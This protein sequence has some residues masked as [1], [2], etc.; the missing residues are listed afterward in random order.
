MRFITSIILLI[1]ICN[2]LYGQRRVR[3]RDFT[4]SAKDT[5]GAIVGD[6]IS[7][8]V[9]T[10]ALK[11]L[12]MDEGR[13]AYL[14]QKESGTPGNAIFNGT[15]S[16]ITIVDD[17][18]LTFSD[19]LSDEPFSISFWVYTDSFSN[20]FLLAKGHVTGSDAEWQIEADVGSVLFFRLTDTGHSP[21]QVG[22]GRQVWN[23]GS[24]IAEYTGSWVLMTFTYNGSG[25]SSG[26]RIYI[27]SSRVDDNNSTVNANSYIAM[28]NTSNDVVIGY[29]GSSLYTDMSI[30]DLRI[31][32][33]EL[34][35][36]EVLN[37]TNGNQINS[38]LVGS[39]KLESNSN[40]L[41][42]N[43]L[44]SIDSNMTYTGLIS[45]TSGGGWFVVIDSAYAEDE[46]IAYDH[47]TSGRQWARVTYRT[48]MVANKIV[49]DSLR[50]TDDVNIFCSDS[51][52]FVIGADTFV[53][54]TKK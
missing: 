44:T 23:G 35:S 12:N 31:Y 8:P 48:T 11:L 34:S 42:G 26:L 36:S 16:Y 17:D 20:A 10:T 21:L 14:K 15:S 45:D 30:H 2:I 52:Y 3:G 41:G 4:E 29:N 49:T 33:K 1:L 27:N 28:Q 39:W 24:G 18:N 5:I 46:D 53:I 40:D 47:P 25:D 37:I 32:N 6:S 13:V 50:I 54:R 19:G 22:I 43:S 9:D 51:L 7:F 38:N